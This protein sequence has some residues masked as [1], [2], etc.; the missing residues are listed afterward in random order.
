MEAVGG[1][2]VLR[3]LVQE[4]ADLKHVGWS[5]HLDPA[6]PERGLCMNKPLCRLL[7]ESS[8]ALVASGLRCPCK[9]VYHEMVAYWS[10]CL[11]GSIFNPSV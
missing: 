5:E 8:T 7:A 4:R 1:T 9:D 2:S 3:K 6:M 10:V 11:L